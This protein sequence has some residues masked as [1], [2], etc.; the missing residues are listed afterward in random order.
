MN[1][2]NG[3]GNPMENQNFNIEKY[4]IEGTNSVKDYILLIRTNLLHF[5]LISLL[6]FSAFTAYA[7][8]AKSIYKSTVTLK[9]NKQNQNILASRELPEVDVLRSDR[10]IANEIEVINQY[11]SREKYAKALIDS[12]NNAKEKNL[13]KVLK[14]EEEA[15]SIGHKPLKDIAGILKNV[16]SA[17]Q[18]SG[19][20][21]V[22]ISASSPSPYE[23]AL[24]ANTCADKYLKLNLEG[25]RNQLTSLRMFLEKQSKEKLNELNI[26]EDTLRK[27]QERGGI[28]ALDAQSTVLI[29]QLAQLDA[30]RD[31]AKIELMSSNEVLNQYKNEVKKQ[32]PQLVD[33]LE[34]QTSQVYMDVL[35]KQIAELQVTR[36]ISIANKSPNA[37]VASKI[38]EYDKKITELKDKLS[39]LINDIKANAFASSPEQIK[40]LTQKLIEE[41]INNNSLSIKFKEL[42]T[43]ISK[44]EQD[45][46]RLPKTTIELAQYQRKKESH[47]QLYLL[48]DQKYQE[49]LI[50]ELSQPGN[51]VIVDTGRIPDK[52]AKP[53]RILIIIIGL[54]LG[55][56]FAFGYL[57]VKDYFDDTIKSPRDMEDNDISFLSWV[58]RLNNSTEIPPD[59][60]E[61]LVLYEPD[62]PISESFRAIE[63][64]IEYSRAESE[65]PKLILVTS[66]AEGEGKTFIAFN[67]AGSFAQSNKRT[68]LIDCDLRR[69]KIHKIF[70]VD[71]KPGLVDYLF[72][73]A[74]LKDI[75]RKTKIDN[76]SYITSGSIPSNSA[77]VLKSK[78]MNSFLKGIRDCFDAIIIDSAPIVAAIDAEILAK[79]VDGTILVVS[80]DK[81]DH[82]L[83]M[84]AVDI[85]KRDKVPFLGTVLNNFKYKNG[86]GYYYKY[87]Y[88]YSSSKGKGNKN[89]KVKS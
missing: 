49:A 51:V 48:V 56:V 74:R 17:E 25:N 16:I 71:K 27:F 84:D 60:Q 64:R 72:D 4:M 78:M 35:Q 85:I 8:F 40:V 55:P 70:G 3:T 24:I 14:S 11:D 80:A 69:P 1:K 19:L 82:R 32:N 54:T 68:L 57:L 88:S 13:F 61:L 66:P 9:I 62:S 23:A 10:F 45:L 79:L 38:Q 36:D 76:L 29:T 52:P 81:T 12:F 86:Y 50:N 26:A 2:D 15:G 73:D 83:M 28:V 18:I 43:I 87:Y 30:Q 34:N 39:V 20:D 6:I 5:V 46:N 47:Q 75:I 63:A 77:K 42:Q 65:F 44:Y 89:H 21:L 22:E 67:L 41:E 58:P 7:F 53:N 33:Y 31:A 59:N 37:V